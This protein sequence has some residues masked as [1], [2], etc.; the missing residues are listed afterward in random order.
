MRMLT[1]MEMDTVSGGEKKSFIQNLGPVHRRHAH[2]RRRRGGDRGS[3]RRQA[4]PVFIAILGAIC[5]Q[6][7]IRRLQRTCRAGILTDAYLSW[8]PL[9]RTWC[10]G[11]YRGDGNTVPDPTIRAP[12]DSRLDHQSL[13]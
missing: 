4:Q 13:T 2:G 12:M 8:S 3:N 7:G 5:L 10:G 6:L 1:V 9:T 11:G